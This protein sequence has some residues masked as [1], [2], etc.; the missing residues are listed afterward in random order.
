MDCLRCEGACCETFELPIADL[1]PPS[2]DAWAWLFVRGESVGGPLFPWGDSSSLRFESRCPELTECGRCELH[3]TPDKPT[4]CVDMK[5]G[6]DDCL[7]AVRR[8][9]TP[10]QYQQIR[11][12]GD[13]VVLCG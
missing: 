9:R 13:P 12:D 6:C 11:E 2:T 7:D 3:G 8:R 10:E 4:V 1:N 5:P